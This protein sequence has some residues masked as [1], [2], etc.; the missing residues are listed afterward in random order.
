MM[1]PGEENIIYFPAVFWPS[2]VVTRISFILT[3]GQSFSA[4][5]QNSKKARQCTHPG[6][7]KSSSVTGF[8]MIKDTMRTF[9]V[10]KRFPQKSRTNVL[11]GRR[12]FSFVLIQREN[13]QI[14]YV[15]TQ[16]NKK[17]RVF[18]FFYLSIGRPARP[19]V[20]HYRNLSSSNTLR[21]LSTL[22]RYNRDPFPFSSI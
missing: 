12:V 7:D 3:F 20:S 19:C 11:H 17:E 8:I 16:Q 4:V 21:C 22:P 13:Q 10:R 14:S 6:D 9:F 18:C 15:H 5:F 1:M 2:G